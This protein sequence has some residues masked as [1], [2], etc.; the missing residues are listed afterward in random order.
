[1]N[2]KG[3]DSIMQT[4]F[5]GERKLKRRLMRQIWKEMM[6]DLL[7]KIFGRNSETKTTDPSNDQET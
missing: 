2:Q 5:P 6:M 4:V 3:K 7:K 1:M